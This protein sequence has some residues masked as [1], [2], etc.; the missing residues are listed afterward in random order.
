[1]WLLD[2]LR[3]HA[4]GRNLHQLAVILEDVFGPRFDDNFGGLPDLFACALV[5]DA[6]AVQFLDGRGAAQA[7]FDPAVADDIEHGSLFRHLD[8]MVE[9]K[10]QQPHAM[11][12]AN[13][14]G[15][16]ADGAK[17]HFGRGTMRIFLQEV[18]LDLPHEIETEPIAELDLL[19]RL[20]VDIVFAAVIPRPGHLHFKMQTEFHNSSV[21]DVLFDS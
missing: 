9:L 2:R 4:P 17:E 8:G 14:F 11:G 18:M 15:A 7:K 3:D 19:Q 21:I 12:D 16:L 1:M 13:I 10:R 6:E 20:P 5:I